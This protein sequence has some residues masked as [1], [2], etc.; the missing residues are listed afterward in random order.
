M[1]RLVWRNDQEQWVKNN[2]DSHKLI[3]FIHMR[4]NLISKKSETIFTLLMLFLQLFLFWPI[5]GQLY[6]ILLYT[7]AF[8]RR[9]EHWHCSIVMVLQLWMGWLPGHSFN[10]LFLGEHMAA[11]IVGS[12]TGS[13]VEKRERI[14]FFCCLFH[15]LTPVLTLVLRR[16]FQETWYWQGEPSAEAVVMSGVRCSGT[17]LTLDQWKRK[18]TGTFQVGG[19]WGGGGRNG[20]RKTVP[21]EGAQTQP[22]AC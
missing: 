6:W 19:R 7:A 8:Y 1:D 22:S 17:E 13:Q 12:K 18:D 14:N 21:C 10:L 5:S 15:M 2:I 11:E 4:T 16:S 9:C 20:W 3:C